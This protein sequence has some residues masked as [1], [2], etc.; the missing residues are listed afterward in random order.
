MRITHFAKFPK[1]EEID[2]GGG[3]AWS[4]E[5]LIVLAPRVFRNCAIVESS[6]HVS[7]LSKR[8]FDFAANLDKLLY[9]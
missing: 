2:D 4:F 6:L 1:G 9:R 3:C 8:L 7:S 5:H